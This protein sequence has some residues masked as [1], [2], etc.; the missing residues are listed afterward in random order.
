M[1]HGS[2]EDRAELRRTSMA[3]S[4]KHETLPKKKRPTKTKKRRITKHHD[5]DDEVIVIEDDDED[6]EGPDYSKVHLPRG[7]HN[8]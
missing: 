6:E 4:R 8:L 7:C 5:S 2:P 3:L 1:Y